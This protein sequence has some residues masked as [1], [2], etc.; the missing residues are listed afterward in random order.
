MTIR[1]GG[2]VAEDPRAV[3]VREDEV[4]EPRH[5]PRRRGRLRI[6]QRRARKVVEH[7]PVLARERPQRHPLERLRDRLHPRHARPLADVL[8]RRRPVGGEVR[9]DDLVERLLRRG[10]RAAHLPGSP[11][12]RRRVPAVAPDPGRGH[13]D[14]VRVPLH[15]PPEKGRRHT[16]ARVRLEQRAHLLVG[17][18]VPVELRLHVL[19]ELGDPRRRA[20]APRTTAARATRRA[21]PDRHDRP[22]RPRR[23]DVQR[24]RWSSALTSRAA[25][26]RLRQLVALEPLEPGPERQVRARRRL[27]LQAAEPLD[28]LRGPERPALE[29][30]LA[31][32]QGAVEL[33]PCEETLGAGHAARLASVRASDGADRLGGDRHREAGAERRN[34]D[35]ARRGPAR[36][37]RGVGADELRSLGGRSRRDP[38]TAAE[39]HLADGTGRGRGREHVACGVGRRRRRR[40]HELGGCRTCRAVPGRPRQRPSHQSHQPGLPGPPALSLLGL[41]A[42]TCR[43]RRSRSGR[44]HLPLP[45]VPQ[46]LPGPAGPAGPAAPVAPRRT[47]RACRPRGSRCTGRTGCT[48]RASRPR[49]SCRTGAPGAPL[50]PV[51]PVGPAGPAG[52]AAPVAP[53]APGA[54]AMRRVHATGQRLLVVDDSCAALRSSARPSTR[55]SSRGS[56]ARRPHILV[57]TRRPTTTSATRRTTSSRT[58]TRSRCGRCRPGSST[59]APR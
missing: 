21:A 5:E 2:D 56:R 15:A 26:E 41:P 55:A 16:L 32:Q 30:Q 46:G 1:D 34:R 51:A 48:S 36:R 47:C 10:R 17:Q 35:D 31:L 9:A 22:V 37:T 53:G 14:H 24:P 58:A 11:R 28:R 23:G 29:Q 12:C 42:A 44:S 7:L 27:R 38:R 18:L 45:L 39:E 52:P 40:G 19:G 54:P 13:V 6:G 59:R 49:R 8:L 33:A 20:A 4:V 50:A 25:G 57:L 3:G 43:T